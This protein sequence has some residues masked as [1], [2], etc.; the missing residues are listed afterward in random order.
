[1]MNI[2]K[3]LPFKYLLKILSRFSEKSFKKKFLENFT[4]M[5]W[6]FL[7]EISSEYFSLKPC[8]DGQK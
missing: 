4:I 6:V 2:S 7:I 8:L 5:C 1:M 3:F